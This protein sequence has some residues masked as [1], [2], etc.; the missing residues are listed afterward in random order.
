M[1][2]DARNAP[3]SGL[4]DGLK[5][6]GL[7]EGKEI[8]YD[9]H[10]AK[11]QRNKLLALAKNIIQGQPDIA[12]AAGGVETDA[13]KIA[14]QNTSIPV[15]FLAVSSSV[16]RH[17]VASLKYPGGNMTGLDTNDTH[18]VAK[19]LWLIKKIMPKAKNIFIPY[20]AS[21]TPSKQSIQVAQS[22]AKKLGLHLTTISFENQKE[23]KQLGNYITQENIDAILMVPSAPIKEALKKVL[24]PISLQHKLPIFT[25]GQ[26]MIKKGA[27]ISYASSRYKAGVQVARLVHKVLYGIPPK[28]IP[29]ETPK[30]IELVINRW[31]VEKLGLKLSGRAWRLA[32]EILDIAIH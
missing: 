24:F 11:G 16:E 13:L 26:A 4:K 23:L 3:I 17:L 31:M 32:D 6:L 27:T 22:K 20:T 12:I 29:V 25:Y 1:L 7:I 9:I 5:T 19:R 2:G 30:Y 28:Q 21:I 18:L 10:N 15:V 14:S 8:I